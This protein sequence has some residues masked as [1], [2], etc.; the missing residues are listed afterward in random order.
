MTAW[1]DQLIHTLSDGPFSGTVL[2]YDFNLRALLAVILVSLVCGAVGSLVVGNR[3]AFFSDALAHCAFAGVTLG[4]VLGYFTGA[5][6]EEGY[7][8]WIT[9]TTVVFGVA[10]GLAIAFVREV[11]GQAHDTIIGVFFA[12]AIGLG[13]IFLK[14]GS[15][16]R[17]MAPETFLFGSPVTVTPAE[18]LVLFCL[19]VVTAGLLAWLY[20]GLTL[21]SFNRS[22][23]LSRRVRVRLCSY[24]FIVL[25]GLI[26]N[27][28]LKAVG[29]LLIN[30]L[31]IVP[32]ATAAL[33]SR[34]M[35]QVFWGSVGL[36]L[37]AG[38]GGHLLSLHARI[39][40]VGTRD[41]AN[42]G[43]SGAIV[44]LSVLLFFVALPLS[45]WLRRRKAGRVAQPVA[46]AAAL[47][48]DGLASAGPRGE[49]EAGEPGGPTS[50]TTGD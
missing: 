6:S 33:L 1:L 3:M 2:Q 17:F 30:G 29:A 25:L 5:E 8:V 34:N 23:A 43:E 26:V 49:N 19:V 15:G 31:L 39:P 27:L 11:S 7:T 13:A 45:A 48:R 21:T 12:G 41:W 16:R 32:A 37:L 9:L 46:A 20:N 44:L 22:L 40:V 14:V 42:P 47:A 28:C 4:L 50:R 36:C 18:L 24:L 38:A 10:V 35:R